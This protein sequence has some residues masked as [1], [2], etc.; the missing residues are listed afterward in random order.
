V[1]PDRRRAVAPSSSFPPVAPSASGPTEFR[2]EGTVESAPTRPHHSPPRTTGNG[3]R[4]PLT[5]H[6]PLL[7]REVFEVR[8][9]EDVASGAAP[10]FDIEIPLD[11]LNP[12]QIAV[13]VVGERVATTRLTTLHGAELVWWI[14]EAG[15]RGMP[16]DIVVLR[17]QVADR[18]LAALNELVQ[19]PT[20]GDV[21]AQFVEVKTTTASGRACAMSAREML[22]AHSDGA[23]ELYA[24]HRV[25]L[26]VE[27]GRAAVTVYECV[28]RALA[29]KRLHLLVAEAEVTN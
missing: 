7:A 16:F 27:N 15:E 10:S 19:S 26:S 5:D 2:R 8:A 14:N 24:L 12:S 29:E 4:G 9:A 13:G 22:F 25:L 17:R 3:E 18:S 1:T 6:S 20:G 11:S 21:V 23:R 28:A